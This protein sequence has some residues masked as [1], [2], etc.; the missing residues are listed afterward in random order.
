MTA[1]DDRFGA[2][3]V[4]EFGGAFDDLRASLPANPGGRFGPFGRRSPD[5][6]TILAVHHTAGNRDRPWA[7]IARDHLL[8]LA[9]GGRLEAAGIGYHVGI[10]RGRIAYLGDVTTSRAC[11]RRDN[12][13]MLCVVVAGDYTRETLDP[14]DRDALRRVVA[15]V[16]AFLGRR[17]EIMGH[18]QIPGQSTECP[19]GAI[20]AALPSLRGA[21]VPPP[22]P[23]QDGALAAALVAEAASRQAIRLNPAASLQRA[24]AA[25][26]M[27]PT[28]DEFVV[29]V[30]GV[31]YHGQRAERLAVSRS[32][33]VYYARA[34]DWDAV[35]FLPILA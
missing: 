22:P 25:A 32:A 19:G 28:S 17:T 14:A 34:G 30:E 12:D 2:M 8:P 13:R 16:D 1:Q 4:A 24:I 9:Q 29:V 26:G 7:D 5:A 27:V 31:T 23:P 15:V 35:R 6:V 33:R 18:G 10:R 11:V 21:P 20:L 3:L